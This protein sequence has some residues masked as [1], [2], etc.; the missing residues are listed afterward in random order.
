MTRQKEGDGEG[1]NLPRRIICD[2]VDGATRP[3]VQDGN[4]GP[5]VVQPQV[6]QI[7]AQAISGQGRPPTRRNIGQHK[8]V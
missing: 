2:D 5:I 6:C 8:T 1:D 3:L 4:T 7:V